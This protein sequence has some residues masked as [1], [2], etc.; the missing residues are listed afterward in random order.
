MHKITVDWLR[1]DLLFFSD[2]PS[3]GDSIRDAQTLLDASTQ[4]LAEHGLN[5]EDSLHRR[6]LAG[7]ESTAIPPTGKD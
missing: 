5:L 4:N 1:Q 2:A 7:I 6:L 3:T